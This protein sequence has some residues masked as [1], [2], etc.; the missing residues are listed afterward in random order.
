MYYTFGDL[1]IHFSVFQG[2]FFVAHWNGGNVVTDKR[3]QFIQLIH[4][5][6]NIDKIELNRAVNDFF[7]QGRVEAI[8]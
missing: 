6:T 3:D 8:D 4:Q 5:Q 2:S 7:G 1:T